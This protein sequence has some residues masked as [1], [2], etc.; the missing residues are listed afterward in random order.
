MGGKRGM[1]YILII[2]L[3]R[4]LRDKESKYIQTVRFID[5]NIGKYDRSIVIN[6]KSSG[7]KSKYKPDEQM[8]FETQGVKILEKTDDSIE[9]LMNTLNKESDTVD[10]VGCDTE[11]NVMDILFRLQKAGFERVNILKDYVYTLQVVQ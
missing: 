9:W 4:E 2:D 10:I 11:A 7:K 3:Q 1:H 8:D 5:T 6:R